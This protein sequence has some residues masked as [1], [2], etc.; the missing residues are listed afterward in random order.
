MTSVL[1]ALAAAGRCRTSLGG[2]RSSRDGFEV[3]VVVVA[4][5]APETFEAFL[6][7]SVV[8]DSFW[9]S[10]ISEQSHSPW[11]QVFRTIWPVLPS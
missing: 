4:A 5:A 3:V 1:A 10:R 9:F 7:L 8:L 6:A 2:R 11:S